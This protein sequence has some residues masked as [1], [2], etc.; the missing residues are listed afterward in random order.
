VL[1]ELE[2]FEQVMWLDDD[3]FQFGLRLLIEGIR[4][5]YDL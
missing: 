4:C 1:S 3:Q 5:T 2:D